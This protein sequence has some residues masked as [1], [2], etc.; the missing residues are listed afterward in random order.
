MTQRLACH[1]LDSNW[2]LLLNT[3]GRHRQPETK[4]GI[5][6]QTGMPG[7]F[8]SIIQEAPSLT[9]SLLT[10]HQRRPK[11]D[12]EWLDPPAK[13]DF[14][15]CGKCDSAQGGNISPWKC[16]G[17]NTKQLKWAAKQIYCT[18]SIISHEPQ[19]LKER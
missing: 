16:K 3:G 18:T 1:R 7:E 17:G 9:F 8:P 19:I 6:F 10:F 13:Q 4:Y 14:I 5:P 15:L 2:T 11:E 12:W